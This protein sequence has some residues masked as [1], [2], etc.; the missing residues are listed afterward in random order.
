[1][2]IFIRQT[3]PVHLS[4]CVI[5][6]LML[7]FS[8]CTFLGCDKSFHC[9]CCQDVV[10]CREGK[11][12]GFV[13]FVGQNCWAINRKKGNSYFAYCKGHWVHSQMSEDPKNGC[14]TCALFHYRAE[15]INGKH[16]LY[17]S[18]LSLTSTPCRHWSQSLFLPICRSY[19]LKKGQLER[20]YAQ[21]RLD[22]ILILIHAEAHVYKTGEHWTCCIAAPLT[23]ALI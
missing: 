22:T 20:D 10:W 14:Y 7:C 23:V 6:Y 21:V 12:R 3:L 5:E 11:G 17:I 8:F 13:H 1:M 19:S 18:L 9:L 15:T 16:K 4:V 2:H